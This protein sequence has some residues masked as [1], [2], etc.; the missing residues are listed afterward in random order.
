MSQNY[1]V[2]TTPD[3]EQQ[4]SYNNFFGLFIGRL[5]FARAVILYHCINKN[6]FVSKMTSNNPHPWQFNPHEEKNLDKLPDW[7][8]TTEQ[9][10]MFHWYDQYT[11][12]SVDQQGIVDQFVTPNS[13]IETNR[14]L[15]NHYG[16]FAVEIVCETYTMGNTF[17]PTEKTVRPMLLKK[18][19]IVMGPKCFLIYLRQ[20]GF[21]TFNDFWSEDYDGY[22]PHLKYQYILNLVDSIA[23]K[24][25]EELYKM[26][27]D[28]HPILNHNYNL[29]VHQSYNKKIE[30]VE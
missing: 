11:I 8:T 13:Y 27:Q 4:L 29:L 7:L 17:F 12:P 20:L 26:Y 22:S 30:Y 14:S 18:P 19:F 21:K 3:I 25:T 2:D 1:W 10:Q 28:M 9:Y 23:N 16:R 15:L 5:T 6:V 24:S